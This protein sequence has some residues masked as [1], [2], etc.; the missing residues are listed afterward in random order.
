[1]KKPKEKINHSLLSSSSSSASIYYSKMSA[2]HIKKYDSGFSETTTTVSSNQGI[3]ETPLELILSVEK[4]YF[5]HLK[6]DII[7]Y[8]RPLRRYLNPDEIVDLFQ[9]I[10]KVCHP[11]GREERSQNLS[12]FPQISAISESIVRQCEKLLHR[13]DFADL[14]IST[15]YQSWVSCPI[16]SK[17]YVWARRSF[18]SL[19]W[20][21]IRTRPTYREASKLKQ[22][23]SNVNIR[24]PIVYKSVIKTWRRTDL[25]DHRFSLYRCQRNS[26]NARSL[27]S[28]SF[29]FD[30]SVYSMISSNQYW[31]KNH[32]QWIVTIRRLLKV[33]FRRLSRSNMHVDFFQTFD[34]SL[35]KHTLSCNHPICT[36]RTRRS[37]HWNHQ[38]TKHQMWL[39]THR[40]TPQCNPN[41]HRRS[42][43]NARTRTHGNWYVV[44]ATVTL[45]SY[46]CYV[47]SSET[48]G[49][50]GGETLVHR[51]GWHR[52]RVVI[53]WTS[54]SG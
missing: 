15:I 3:E 19:V 45:K 42:S 5:E 49:I 7:K 23:W 26:S 54:R 52:D 1:M 17:T 12:R 13:E 14:S 33:K 20:W 8:S 48:I 37:R 32:L 34:R 29:R 11:Q 10:E 16:A 44:E 6:Q 28:F 35:N 51:D 24:S 27:H 31:S 30:T 25:F 2:P 41:Y 38:D 43:C 39:W 36:N 22:H 50:V 18:N 4:I 9:N 46:L 53:Q 40:K 21:S 47:C